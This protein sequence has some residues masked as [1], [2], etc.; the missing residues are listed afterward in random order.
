MYLSIILT[1]LVIETEDSV[2]VIKLNEI[3]AIEMVDK[4]SNDGGILTITLKGS[5]SEQIVLATL[6]DEKWQ[7]A[8][9]WLND[10]VFNLS[11]EMS[12]NDIEIQRTVEF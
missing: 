9:K 8:K 5:K 4:G 7:K 12:K 10:G 6:D 2:N 11:R 3:Q 1:L